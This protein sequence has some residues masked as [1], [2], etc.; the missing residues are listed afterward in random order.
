MSI[1]I[2]NRDILTSNADVIVQQVNC[3]NVMG[4]GL[5]LSIYSKYYENKK[6][7]HK[8]VTKKHKTKKPNELLGEVLYVD[9]YDGKIIANIFGQ[10]NIRKNK[11]DKNVYT[12]SESLIK[13]LMNVKEKCEKLGF[14]VAIP[15]KI[16]CDMANGNWD[17]IKPK[18]E[19][20]F[21]DSDV[22]VVF[23]KYKK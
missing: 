14:S 20:V 4:G 16:G 12:S 1:K 17:E 23:Y 15:Y 6:E 7:Y 10:E 9:T 2:I 11:Y 22:D 8:F 18:I 3:I 19:A 21:E 13:G 5:A